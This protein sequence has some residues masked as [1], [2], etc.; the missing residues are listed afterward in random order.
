M[1]QSKVPIPFDESLLR[2][3]N[4]IAECSPTVQECPQFGF[5]GQ[6][7]FDLV[8]KEA[9]FHNP[10][11]RF[12]TVCPHKVVECCSAALVEANKKYFNLGRG[13]LPEPVYGIMRGGNVLQHVVPREPMVKRMP[14]KDTTCTVSR[15]LRYFKAVFTR[16]RA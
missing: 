16:T 10:V 2:Q 11:S 5:I 15:F 1:E 4:K 7:F 12:Y 3:R 14:Q 9:A 6:A 13:P 8:S